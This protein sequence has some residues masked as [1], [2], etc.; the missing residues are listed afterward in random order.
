VV[1]FP[2]RILFIK[3]VNGINN[4]PK[5][6]SAVLVFNHQSYFDF[7]CFA[8]IAPRNIHFLAAEKFFD[9]WLWKHVMR[10]TGQIRVDR[11]S[12]DKQNVHSI[13]ERHVACG[14]LIGIF[15]EGTRSPYKYEMLKAFTGAAMYSLKHRLPLIAVGIIGTY[16][17][18]SVHDKFPKIKK[19]VEINIEAPS[20]FVEH[21][22]CHENN[23]ICSVV[24]ESMVRQIEK[25]S[26]KKYPHYEH[27]K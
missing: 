12:R 8:A 1:G 16:D 9:H 26:G 19:I 6:G 10:Y 17:I 20:H 7:L 22:G 13:I 4:I 24:T 25:L 15:P 2:I 3:N 11:K 27:L 21:H 18:H 14:S 23:T 5:N